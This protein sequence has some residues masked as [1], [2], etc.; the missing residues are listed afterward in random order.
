LLRQ[1]SD[2]RLRTVAVN[3]KRILAGRAEPDENLTL[4]NGDTLIVYS[5]TRRKITNIA[6]IAGFTQFLTFVTL[7]R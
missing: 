3:L 1:A 6:A 5:N 7:R 4:R 2:G